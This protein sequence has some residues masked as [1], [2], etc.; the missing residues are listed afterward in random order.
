[1]HDS[2]CL[3]LCLKPI[4]V[5]KPKY[6]YMVSGFKQSFCQC[7]QLLSQDELS[8]SIAWLGASTVNKEV[9]AFNNSKNMQ[10]EKLNFSAWD[11]PLFDVDNDC[12]YLSTSGGW[13]PS[14]SNCWSGRSCPVCSFTETQVFNLK[15]IILYNLMAWL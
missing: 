3:S 6:I 12:V 8:N 2:V 15:G 4:A 10:T 1:M 7:L 14:N 13:V 5:T 9:F 11:F